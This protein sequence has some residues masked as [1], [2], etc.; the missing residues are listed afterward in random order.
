MLPSPNAQPRAPS[1]L[2]LSNSKPGGWVYMM[3]NHLHL[4]PGSFGGIGRHSFLF[5]LGSSGELTQCFWVSIPPQHPP[6]IN[7]IYW[8]VFRTTLLLPTLHTNS[9][10]IGSIHVLLQDENSSAGTEIQTV[11]G[12]P[13]RLPRKK[14]NLTFKREEPRFCY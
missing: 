1:S 11:D 14:P 3:P 8:P 9:L 6:G 2:Y 12:R 13:W 4:K 5:W 10:F 7:S